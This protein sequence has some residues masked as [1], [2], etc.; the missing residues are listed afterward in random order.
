MEDI[1]NLILTR[2]EGETIIIGDNISITVSRIDANKM[3][4]RVHLSVQAPKNLSVHRQEIWKKIE[5]E[6][7]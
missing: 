7:K 4:Q 5:E 6:K 1:G 3:G 2:R